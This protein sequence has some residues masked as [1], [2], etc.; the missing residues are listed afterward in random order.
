M[1]ENIYNEL[2]RPIKLAYE[3][4]S[5][6]KPLRY[7]VALCLP[8]GKKVLL[9]IN[10]SLQLWVVEFMKKVELQSITKVWKLDFNGVIDVIWA[11]TLLT[12]T[13]VDNKLM[14]VEDVLYLS[15]QSCM[16][17]LWGQK[18]KYIDEIVSVLSMG[19]RLCSVVFGTPVKWSNV[20]EVGY[21]V[22]SVGYYVL[23]EYQRY[24]KVLVKVEDVVLRVRYS[25]V[26]DVFRLYDG[27][28][29]YVGDV[30]VS[31]L[32]QSR[33]LLRLFGVKVYDVLD[34]C[35]CGDVD[36]GVYDKDYVLHFKASFNGKYGKWELKEQ[37]YTNNISTYEQIKQIEQQHSKK[38]K[39][40]VSI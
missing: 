37:V 38:R 19:D 33:M 6:V 1:K 16:M 39:Y 18:F 28:D 32:R 36:V 34:E 11:N 5:D 30:C 21:E 7:D 20:S 17:M 3:V 15:N 14:S 35:M 12:C 4:V 27:V 8:R 40:N 25:G 9:F 2:P 26:L 10:A 29:R 22:L 13:L 23:M 24:V 31:T